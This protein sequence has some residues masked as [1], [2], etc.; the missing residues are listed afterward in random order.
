MAI[1]QIVQDISSQISFTYN[2]SIIKKV[3]Q[4]ILSFNFHTYIYTDLFVQVY[5]CTYYLKLDFTIFEH[6]ND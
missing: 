3:I 2:Q 6:L 4:N 5:I 1:S